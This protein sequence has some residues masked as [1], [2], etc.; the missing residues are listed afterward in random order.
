MCGDR[1]AVVFSVGV[2]VGMKIFIYVLVIIVSVI[3]CSATDDWGGLPVAFT[4][5]VLWY[6]TDEFTVKK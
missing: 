4:L 1:V 3:T 5:C 2:G 6:W